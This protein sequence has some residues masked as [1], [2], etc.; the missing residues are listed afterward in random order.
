MTTTIILLS[1]LPALLYG[2]IIYITVPYKT[3]RFRDA[4]PYIIVGLGSVGLLRYFWMFYPEWENVAT[5]LVG[6]GPNENP[7]GFYHAFY[8]IQVSL[9]EELAKLSVFLLYEKYRNRNQKVEDHPIAIMFHVGLISLGFS[10]VEN[11]QYGMMS[12]FP[13]DTLWWRG[14]T[15]VIGHMVFGLFMGYWIAI[16]RMGPRLYDR[17]LLD[18]FM[19]KSKVLRN[20][21]FTF[22]GLLS[23]VILHGV[24]DL[25]IEVNGPKGI[26]GI[27]M[28]LIISLLGVYWCFKNLNILQKRKINSIR[29]KKD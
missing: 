5:S 9:I 17:S 4:L 25:H 6:G 13:M 1:M 16:G 19:N 26:T 2:F 20:I 14:L 3:I 23:A 24:Y 22:I 21:V 10:I 28:L 7:F 12:A 27:Y 8:F 15:A 29:N 18:I 11:I